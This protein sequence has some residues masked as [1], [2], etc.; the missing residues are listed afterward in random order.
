MFKNDD[1]KGNIIDG[2]SDNDTLNGNGGDDTLNGLAGDDKLNGGADND[3]L[4]GGI[5]ND[6]M[7]GGTGNDVYVVDS[8]GDK[9]VETAVGI[10]DGFRDRV[11]SDIS[12][13]LAPLANIED[14]TL[15]GAT[16]FETLNGTGNAAANTL[17]GNSADNILDGGKGVDTFAGHLGNDTYILDDA[18]EADSAHVQEQ[19]DEGIDT[20]SAAVADIKAAID[21]VENY[22]FT[23]SAAWSFTG[24][25][26]DNVITGGT[27]NDTLDGADGNDVLDGGNGVDTLTGGIGDDTFVL[28]NVADKVIENVGEGVDRV[29]AGFNIDLN[30][31]VFAGQELE[32]ITLVGSAIS[33]IGND[34]YN[35]IYGNDN[36]NLLDGGGG[37]DY[38]VG[39]K[40]N[41]VYVYS[42]DAFEQVF[43][44]RGEGIDTVVTAN[45]IDLLTEVTL[46]EHEIEN[47]TAIAGSGDRVFIGNALDNVLTGAEG[48]DILQGGAGAD[49]LTGAEGNDIL[50]GGAGA[51][52]LIGG[53]GNDQYIVYDALDKIVETVKSAAPDQDDADTVFSD[54][55][56]SLA[57]LANVEN[58]V[59]R[60]ENHDVGD[61][62][63]L[64]ATGNALA[65]HLTGNAGDNILDGGAGIDFFDGG[66]GNDI[67]I[68]DN[69]AELANISV[70]GTETIQTALLLNE[71]NGGG[72]A[73]YTYTGKSNWIFDYSGVIGEHR[74]VGSTGSD[75][76]T[77]SN[78][79]DFLDGGKGA[80]TLVG[81]DGDDTYVVDNVGDKI[82]DAGGQADTLVINR[83]VDLRDGKG[84]DAQFV[85]VFEN[86]T[87]SGTAAINIYGSDDW[88]NHL[89]G[90]AG[91]NILDGRG[92]ADIMEGGKGNDTYFFDNQSDTAV[93][94]E[95]EGV[96]TIYLSEGIAGDPVGIILDE[97]GLHEIEN[98]VADGSL[99]FF[100]VTANRLNNVINGASSDENEFFGMEGDDVLT[101][102]SGDDKLYGGIGAD[103]MSGGKGNDLYDVDSA[104]DKVVESV[105]SAAG[106]GDSDRVESWISFSLAGLANVENLTL[107]GGDNTTGI[108]N[109]GANV[110][111]GNGADNILDGGAG[112]DTFEGDFGNDTFILD[113]V[114]EL[115]LVTDAQGLTQSK[116]ASC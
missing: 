99:S 9:V 74:L 94:I 28:D 15:R 65:N 18:K 80:D 24:N 6:T 92:E 62:D 70:F 32:N 106:G 51:D 87:L 61:S 11:T 67:I 73:N 10:G 23:G 27:K 103:L 98:I 114:E 60:G 42:K 49:A 14:L 13:S 83:S 66:G 1:D 69:I 50:Q 8:A 113:H 3:I 63:P 78:G 115:G 46:A 43:E 116:R 110:M 31:G 108:G 25:G 64:N 21:N 75:K 17:E 105:S 48:N 93:E 16:G 111:T 53:A 112:I 38:L 84:V 91:A 101:G 68:V 20:V 44:L 29:I 109:A 2:T 97:D 12:F 79:N 36:A 77:T 85:G 72:F 100:Q 45:D 107:V 104:G 59:L 40:G 41:D 35:V 4:N 54:I 57:N 102:G 81:G 89:I 7:T 26:L 34:F 56:F 30:T 52:T 76:L 47:V 33:A 22:V 39:G 58:I 37:D 19:F 82:T 95:N 88:G 71:T 86:V 90:N 5:G 96:D 55:S